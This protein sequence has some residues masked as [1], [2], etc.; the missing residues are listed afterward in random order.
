MNGEP[1][2]WEA[3]SYSEGKWTVSVRKNMEND[4]IDE[5]AHPDPLFRIKSAINA[6]ENTNEFYVYMD[7]LL[8]AE[9][10]GISKQNRIIIPMR[11]LNEQ[12]TEEFHQFI[13]HKQLW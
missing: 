13:D 4:R 10:R 5:G 11:E 12:Q 6:I 9:I 1:N 8:V 7:N 2:S 3:D